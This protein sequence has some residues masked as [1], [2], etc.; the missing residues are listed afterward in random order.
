M[1]PLA[2]L[3]PF[4]KSFRSDCLSW[5]FSDEVTKSCKARNHKQSTTSQ[6]VYIIIGSFNLNQHHVSPQ[7]SWV[8]LYKV[9]PSGTEFTFFWFLT[10]T[11]NSFIPTV[12]MNFS[13]FFCQ[14][15]ISHIDRCRRE[16]L[17][18]PSPQAHNF[19][20]AS[21]TYTEFLPSPSSVHP[22]PP[23]ISF[24]F[25]N[26]TTNIS[27]RKVMLSFNVHNNQMIPTEST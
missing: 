4:P 17:C 10:V 13:S 11:T 23:L 16:H 3:K 7:D 21:M 2:F 8:A 25:S 5:C 20:N 6:L 19:S 1:L 15:K 14:I 9:R 18:L 22:F 26:E 27:P 12:P 24:D